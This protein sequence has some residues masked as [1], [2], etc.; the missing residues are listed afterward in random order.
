DNDA[1]GI[2]DRLDEDQLGFGRD[3]LLKTRDVVGISPSHVPAER[4]ECMIELIDR[5]AIE[6]VCGNELVAR[7]HQEMEGID[8]RGVAGGDG[9]GGGAALERRD[10]LFEH[11]ACWIADARVDVAKRLKSE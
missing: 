1:A 9:E 4:L 11:V 2:G 5:A 8:L 10:P 3:G 7:R 6:F